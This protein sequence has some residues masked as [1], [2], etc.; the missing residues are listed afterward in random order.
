MQWGF[1]NQLNELVS[2]TQPADEYVQMAEVN[3]NCKQMY[4]SG[5]I[6]D[7]TNVTTQWAAVQNA[8]KPL[9]DP[10]SCGAVD[11]ATTLPQIKTAATAAGIDDIKAELEKQMQAHMAANPLK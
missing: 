2:T 7:P 4:C 3:K 6:F 8:V 11:P 1:G 10:V 5:F 9:L